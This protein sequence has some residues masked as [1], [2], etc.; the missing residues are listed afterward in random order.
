MRIISFSILLILG[1]L[2]ASAQLT[3]AAFETRYKRGVNFVKN[4]EWQNAQ[5]EFSD[6]ILSR[7]E[8]TL[9]PYAY[10]FNGLSLLKLM[11]LIM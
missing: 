11:C 1:C 2:Q 7:A 4:S 6:L 10:Y 9:V 8:N 5:T 3:N